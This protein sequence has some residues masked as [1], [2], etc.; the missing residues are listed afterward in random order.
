MPIYTR[1]GDEGTTSF[2]GGQR[3]SKA[4]PRV[5]A[6]GALDEAASAIGL[7]AAAPLDS[8]TLSVLLFAQQR[9]AT[10]ASVVAT[11]PSARRPDS[12]FIADEDIACLEQAIDWFAENAPPFEGFVL[13]GGSEAAARLH[14]SRSIVRRAERRV[15][16]VGLEDDADKA[17][18][19]F[20]NRLSD[21]LFAAARA[22]LAA[23]D[24]PE[25]SW[26]PEAPRPEFGEA[27]RGRAG[28]IQDDRSARNS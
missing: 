7:A 16:A 6:Y 28:G 3:A 15:V 8:V 25:V 22:S 14:L 21:A 24:T 9:L 27:P 19:R 18:V 12:P 1:T 20:L 4:D 5:D 17:V 10:A 13:P 26:D 2:V 11:P 23:G